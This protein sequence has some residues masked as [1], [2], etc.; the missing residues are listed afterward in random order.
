[1]D[2]FAFLLYIFNMKE[3][4]D[5]FKE[6]AK[7]VETE[8]DCK[9][10]LHDYTGMLDHGDLPHMHFAGCCVAYKKSR[11]R[12]HRLCL[13]FDQKMVY[14]TMTLKR[15]G[16]F[17]L[18]HCRILEAV[19]PVY[20][21]GTL[22]GVIFA[23]PFA[24]G[25][26]ELVT[27]ASSSCSQDTLR[28]LDASDRSRLMAM[29]EMLASYLGNCCTPSFGTDREGMIKDYLQHKA[30]HPDAGITQLSEILGLSA[31]RTSEA[32]KKIFGVNFKELLNSERIRL[33]C[34][35]LEN[36]AYSIEEI[37]LKTGFRD[38]TYLH[39]VFKRRLKMTPG[40]Y[41]HSSKQ[42]FSP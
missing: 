36:T 40:E 23:G 2:F 28:K 20:C 39:R 38:G 7:V 18:C 12:N 3:N 1:M 11:Q 13:A 30:N 26:A 8:F 29:G 34:Q 14:E 17:K 41:R 9:L 15:R 19:F 4:I 21:R 35:Y 16:F 27:P 33:A 42:K 32:V 10:C 25:D 5:I 37:A 24:S 31:P 6:F 22:A